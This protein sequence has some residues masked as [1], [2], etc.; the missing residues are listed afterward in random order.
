MPSP[1]FH[2]LSISRVRLLNDSAVALTFSIPENLVDNF[3]FIPGQYLTLRSQIGGHDI[4]RAY[5]ICSDV[6]S[7]ELEVGIKSVAG[8]AFSAYALSLKVGDTLNVM[9][10]QG[11]FTAPIGGQHNYLLIAAGSGITPCLSIIK[12]VL[13]AES[14]S[15]ITLI[16]ANRSRPSILFKEDLD[17]L[18]DSFTDRLVVIH[19]LS[20]EQQAIEL[21]QGRL[22]AAKFH[23]MIKIGMINPLAHDQI[24]L[25][26]PQ[27]MLPEL[28]ASLLDTGVPDSIINVEVFT[29][30]NAQSA[31]TGSTSRS[32]DASGNKSDSKMG[33][34][35]GSLSDPATSD[36]PSTQVEIILD[37]T[38][39]KL[40]MNPTAETVL[41][42]ARRQGIDLPFSC[43]G[44]MCCTCRCK[45]IAGDASM[46]INYS[47]QKWEIDAGF[48]L[49]CQTRPRSNDLLLDFDAS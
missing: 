31:F 24:Y 32:V 11:R 40:L 48:T 49:A 15:R 26:G 8:G 19:V 46:D 44:G 35:S 14:N 16:Y 7:A 28:Q 17:G 5:S 39:H 1:R 33:R 29:N 2:D 22:N 30:A 23:S 4:R 34:G 18:K 41:G 37:G 38:R 12:S 25:C 21:L 43:A 13:Q 45:I 9:A 47:L 36:A 6:R 27:A 3:A 10:P 20:G 42:A